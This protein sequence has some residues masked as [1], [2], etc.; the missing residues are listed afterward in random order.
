MT[1]IRKNIIIPKK[2]FE[3]GDNP[4]WFGTVE[5]TYVEIYYDDSKSV[6]SPINMYAVFSGKGFHGWLEFGYTMPEVIH[7]SKTKVK[8]YK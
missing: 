2:I 1:Y 6:R 3:Q 7:V 8:E 5:D 4:Q